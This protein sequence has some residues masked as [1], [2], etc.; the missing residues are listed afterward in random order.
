VY[1]RQ[2][3]Y[4]SAIGSID[5]P[6]MEIADKFHLV[7]NMSER[8]TRLI[9][10]HYSDYRNA[11]RES[12]IAQEKLRYDQLENLVSSQNSKRTDSRMIKFIE[13]KKNAVKRM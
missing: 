4:S 9:G 6:I 10:E 12:K 5:R 1:K 11:V 7:K 8:F 3:A 13:V 2:S